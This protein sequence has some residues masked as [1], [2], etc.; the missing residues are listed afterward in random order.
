M[1]QHVAR[2]AA[3]LAP[4][5]GVEVI[6]GEEVSCWMPESR[7]EVHFGVYGMTESLHRDLQ[8]LRRNAFEVAAALRQANVF[9]ALNHLLHF[10]RGQIPFDAYLRLLR[11][12]PAVE[13]RNGT[14]IPSH[15]MLVE[16]IANRSSATHKLGM[17]AG[18]D[19]HT[20]RRVGLTWTEA[21]GRTREEFLES[22]RRGLG[23]P[24]G[25]HG[26]PRRSTRFGSRA[27][28]GRRCGLAT[29][30]GGLGRAELD[31]DVHQGPAEDRI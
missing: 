28:L 4:Q 13:A 29:A 31:R 26:G 12:V 21:P 15:N 7:I 19:A 20:L 6:V 10:Y 8:P 5:F 3:Q 9:F 22:L 14:M 18:S 17:T 25:C 11:E 24:G 23:R 2:Q 27:S 16:W 1:R 30:G